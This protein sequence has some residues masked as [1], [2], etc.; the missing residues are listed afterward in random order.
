MIEGNNLIRN[1]ETGRRIERVKNGRYSRLCDNFRPI[2]EP[3]ATPKSQPATT[4][5]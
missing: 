1:T 4:R 3:S 5:P 2:N